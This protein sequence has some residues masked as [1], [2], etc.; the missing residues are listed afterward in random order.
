MSEI[1]EDTKPDGQ[2]PNC[3]NHNIAHLK[4]QDET[5]SA[6]KEQVISRIRNSE[7][8]EQDVEIMSKRVTKRFLPPPRVTT[9][10]KPSLSE[11]VHP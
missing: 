9:K 4:E 11:C 7:I 3:T 10:S 6:L 8:L 2:P 5:L 1:D